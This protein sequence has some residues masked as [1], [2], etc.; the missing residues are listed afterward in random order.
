[1]LLLS[2]LG[3]EDRLRLYLVPFLSTRAR[4]LGLKQA[5]PTFTPANIPVVDTL[6]SKYASTSGEGV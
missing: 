5:G 2:A 6:K 1:M 4:L 3:K